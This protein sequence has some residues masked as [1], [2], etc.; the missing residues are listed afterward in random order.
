MYAV[1]QQGIVEP[2]GVAVKIFDLEIAKKLVATMVRKQRRT[3]TGDVVVFKRFVL[4]VADQRTVILEIAVVVRRVSLGV[5][6]EYCSVPEGF[7]KHPR[8]GSSGS[9]TK[10]S[11]CRFAGE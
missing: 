6:T 3:V 2:F 1:D 8:R 5:E 11:D 4:I 7:H 9:K 10:I